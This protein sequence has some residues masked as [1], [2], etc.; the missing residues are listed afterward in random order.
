MI[1][2]YKINKYRDGIYEIENFITDATADIFLSLVNLD[3]DEGWNNSHGQ[4]VTSIFNEKNIDQFRVHGSALEDRIKYCFTNVSNCI[5]IMNLRRLKT[6]GYIPSHTDL[7]PGNNQTEIIFGIVIYPNEDYEGG[8]L[9]Y[10]NIDFKLKP[11]KNSL[12]V[13]RS[14]IP[15]EVLPVT[16]GTR[17]SITTFIIGNDKTEFRFK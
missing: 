17:Y 16:S 2:E 4:S 5:P 1:N 8:E 3:G 13:H 15:H 12:V 7:G 6:G 9:Y 11:K 14:T 10:K